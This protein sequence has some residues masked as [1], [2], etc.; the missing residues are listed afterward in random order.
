MGLNEVSEYWHQV[1][2]INNYQKERFAKNI[3]TSLFSTVSEKKITLLGWAFKKDTNDTRESAA[4]YVADLLIENGA[5]INVYDPK[6]NKNQMLY[7]LNSLNTR[8]SIENEK[9]LIYCADPYEACDKSHAVAIITEWDEF[10]SYDWKKI[11]TSLIKPAKIFD[12]RNILKKD[13]LEEIGFQ[14]Y[15]IGKS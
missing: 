5:E 7:D 10:K 9:A 2:K 11:Y 12:G 15:S 6:V 13:V 8:S 1:I 14:V 3:I 4:I